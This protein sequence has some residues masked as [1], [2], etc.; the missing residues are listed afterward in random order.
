M[1][2]RNAAS[3]GIY[4]AN[5]ECDGY[6]GA[7]NVEEIIGSLAGRV[8]IIA[9]GADTVFDDIR[10]AIK[11]IRDPVW[12]GVNDIGMYLPKLDHWVS[13]HADNLSAWKAVRWLNSRSLEIA[14]Y[15]SCT[16]RPVID[17]CWD[18]LTPTFALSGYFAMQIAYIMG[19]DLIVLCG[20]P[21][22]QRRKFTDLFPRE[23]FGYGSGTS[24]GDHGV[25]EQLEKEMERL[26][27]FK[28]KVRSMSGATKDFFGGLETA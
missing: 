2:N 19:A 23:D 14:K 9:G 18:L 6:S 24:G 27:M 5:W 8:A 3:M 12:F 20:V 22:D 13:L 15:H 11:E 28:N 26:P 21:G 4:N 10:Q 7:G 16:Q 17:Y 1:V 25:R